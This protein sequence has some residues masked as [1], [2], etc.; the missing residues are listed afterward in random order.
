MGRCGHS[1]TVQKKETSEMETRC[2]RFVATL[3][4][5][6]LGLAA[7][8]AAAKI[9]TCEAS[10]YG[11]G[12]QGNTMANGETFDMDD[13]TVVA[14]KSYPFGTLLRVTNLNNGKSIV[15]EVQDRGPYAAG[16]CVDLSRAAAKRI[17]V[18]TGPSSGTAPVKVE[19]IASTKK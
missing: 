5:I 6:S 9:T 12:L 17:G 10:W 19:V 13:P 14:H 8:S 11:P 15:L 3:F 16:R 7:S 4:V 1:S 2:R 18:Y